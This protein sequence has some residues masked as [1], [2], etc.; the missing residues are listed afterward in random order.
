MPAPWT[1]WADSGWQSKSETL[2]LAVPVGLAILDGLS[3]CRSAATLLKGRLPEIAAEFGAQWAAVVERSPDWTVL[4]Q[5]GRQGIGDLPTWFLEEALDRDAA[6]LTKLAAPDGWS[7]VAAPF[8][9]RTSPPRL[10]ALAGRGMTVEAVPA[11]LV[12]ARVLAR[13]MEVCADRER[14]DRRLDRFKGTLA[15]A[16]S[17]AGVHETQPLL[18]RI[19][20]EAT[21]LLDC[22]RASIFIRDKRRGQLVACPALGV[23]G[24]TLRLP[25]DAGIVGNV[26]RSGQTVRV[27]AAYQD[28]RFN[29]AVDKQSGYTTRNLLCVALRNGNGEIIGAFEVINRHAGPF[30]EEDEETLELLAGQAAIAIQNTRER[31]QLVRSREQLAEQVTRG[32]RIIGESPAIVALRKT[33]ERLAGTDLPVLVLGES[34]TGKEVVSQ[35]LHYQGA[36]AEHP[37]IAVNCA[38]IPETLLE[39]E[40]FGHEKGAFTDAREMRPGK[41]ELAEGGTLFLDEIGDMS[42][43][44]Q[45]K[46]LRVLEQKVITRVGG[47]Q[48]IPIDVRVIAATNSVLSDRV[49]EK[50]FREDLFYRL[51]VVTL[52]LPPLRK[53]PQ[54]IL[55]LAEHFLAQFSTQANRPPL[56][57][58]DEARRRLLAH[59]WP[60]NV[61]ELRNL[62][63]RIAFL[64]P[65]ERVEADDLAFILSPA[66]PSPFEPSLDLGLMEATQRFQTE[67]IRRAVQRV[68]GNMSEAARLM[69]L[70]RSNLY[71][72]LRQLGMPAPEEAR[73]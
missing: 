19:A 68:G 25:D 50:Q 34:G 32:V 62:M 24:N 9:G 22:D 30:R 63:E 73:E 43:G 64:A 47:S 41:F 5:A 15:I 6:G 33:I 8:P 2:S 38:A 11:A 17:I 21:R 35:A 66:A 57:I 14:N 60:G 49:R 71:R 46:L 16:A 10:L 13:G 70:H 37:F 65:G 56:E 1:S 31:E 18:E 51:S 72:K 48:A 52:D 53:R 59:E 4:A 7:L 42:L 23:A 55:P 36:R 12:V 67:F 58:S 40:L 3:E 28:P 29:P 69:G 45:A 54:D 26:I 61:R 39:S 20:E 27:D 44:G